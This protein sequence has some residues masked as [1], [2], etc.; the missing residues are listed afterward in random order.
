MS[1]II[2]LTDMKFGELTVIYD[3]GIRFMG[4]AVWTCKCNCGNFTNVRS[5]NLIRG[6]TTSC[7]HLRGKNNIE[8]WTTHGC[9]NTHE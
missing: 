2:D 9:A 4:S 3:S 6:N 7:G 8:K 1:K 5:A